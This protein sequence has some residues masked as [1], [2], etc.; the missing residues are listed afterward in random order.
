MVNSQSIALSLT[1]VTQSKY[2]TAFFGE[3]LFVAYF[4][5]ISFQQLKT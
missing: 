1:N 4:S 2:N 5:V 3:L